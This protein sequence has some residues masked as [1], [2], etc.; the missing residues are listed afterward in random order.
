MSRRNQRFDHTACRLHAI[1]AKQIPADHF[2]AISISADANRESV[3][4]AMVAVASIA[5]ELPTR[6]RQQSFATELR[7]AEA[8]WVS[9]GTPVEGTIVAFHDADDVDETLVPCFMLPSLPQRCT[10][11]ID[12]AGMMDPKQPFFAAYMPSEMRR[13]KTASTV[14]TMAQYYANEIHKLW[15]AGPIAVGRPGQPLRWPRWSYCVN[16]G[17]PC[18]FSSSSMVPRRPLTLDIQVGPKNSD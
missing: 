11:F 3:G 1:Q 14:A 9:N 17:I 18:R 15:P 12:L 6:A 16:L 4:S 8:L 10:D 13:A 7:R 5:V 2:D